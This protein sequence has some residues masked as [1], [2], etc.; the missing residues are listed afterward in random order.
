MENIEKV[1]RG[2]ATFIDNEVAPIMPRWKGIAFSAGAALTLEA[3]S[4]D[5]MHHPMIAMMGV[6]DGDNVDV[7]KMYNALKIKAQGKWPIEILGLKMSETD[8]DK[9]YQYIKGA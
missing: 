5:L 1:K 8:L 9:L 3:R 4:N 7:D 6:V 2:I